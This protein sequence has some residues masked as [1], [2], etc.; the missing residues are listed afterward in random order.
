MKPSR[1]P[2]DRKVGS[3]ARGPLRTLALLLTASLAAWLSLRAPSPALGQS[4]NHGQSERNGLIEVKTDQERQA[5]ASLA[6]CCGGCPHEPI[7]TCTCGYADRYRDDVR[8]MIAQGMSLE[9]IKDAWEKRFGSDALTVP[10]NRGG[11]RLLYI[12]PLVLIVA[13]AGIVITALRRFRRREDEKSQVALAGGVP[14]ARADDDE[15][16]KKLDD[17]LK[18]LDSEE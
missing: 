7:L 18:Q 12:A 9:Q 1:S 16:E 5:F 6:C 3:R 13:A 14:P 15:Y 4:M 2:T 11:N 17:E 10:R 8:A